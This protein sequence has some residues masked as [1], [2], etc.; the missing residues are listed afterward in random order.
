MTAWPHSLWLW[1]MNGPF[2]ALRN[3]LPT[4]AA[5]PVLFRATFNSE[6]GIVETEGTIIRAATQLALDQ[7][8]QRLASQKVV[9]VS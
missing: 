6:N 1:T 5:P 8:S 7:V 9:S 3:G 4:D 2:H